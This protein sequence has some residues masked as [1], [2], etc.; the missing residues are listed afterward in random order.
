MDTITTH[1]EL[2]GVRVLEYG[3]WIDAAYAGKM[4]ADLG[5]EVVRVESP[6]GDEPLR[7]SGPFPGDV[8]SL[9][10]SGAHLSLD[11]NKF[12]VTLD[13]TT[14]TGRE[15][16]VWLARWADVLIDGQQPGH[17]DELGLGW[18]QLRATSTRLIVTALSSLGR[19]GPKG[20]FK[21]Y[22]LISWHASGSGHMY[23]GDPD[24]EPL[25]AQPHHA[26]YWGGVAAACATLIALRARELTGRGQFVDVSE[27]EALATLY[28]AVE[29]SDFRQNGAVRVRAS[30]TNENQAPASM[31]RSKDGWIYLMA[32]APH[33]WEGLVRAM[34]DP[35][36]AQTPLFKGTSRQ[37]APYGEEIYNLMTDWVEG[38]DTQE[39]FELCQSNGVPA[40]PVNTVRD[41]LESEHL[42]VRGYWIELRHAVAG[43]LRL[44]GQ[45]FRI[46]GDPWGVD[47]PAP[48]LGEHNERYYSGLLGLPASRLAALRRAGVI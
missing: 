47:R 33:Q 25:L 19:T 17:L 39:L 7:L 36:W 22:D 6:D 28:L 20:R 44:P 12:G 40:S 34:G 23:H 4:L 24:R 46:S 29:V 48:R 45:P 5:A 31:R 13:P 37:R 14:P 2:Q 27:A 35:A 15:L 32:L 11:A 9:E 18:E 1:R 16:F 26:S 8:P 43:R 42:R 10:T 3:P 30:S 21:G 41:L 38:H